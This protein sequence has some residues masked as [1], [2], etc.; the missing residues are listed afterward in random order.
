[1]PQSQH[2]VPLGWQEPQLWRIADDVHSLD[3]A[4]EA[5]DLGNAY[6]GSLDRSQEITLE[7]CMGETREGLW[8]AATFGD[9]E[10]RQ[11]GKGD[12]IQWRELYGATQRAERIAHNAHETGT[13]LQAFQRMEWLL[14]SIYV[15]S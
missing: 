6:G 12:S 7:T 4:R 8:A 9:A 10:P 3:A 1:M 13:A 14:F 2:D 5:I 11:N 15:I